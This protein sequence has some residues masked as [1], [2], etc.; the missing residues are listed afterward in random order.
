MKKSI[1]IIFSFVLLVISCKES[2]TGPLPN[3]NSSEFFPNS[4]GNYYNYNVLVTDSSGMAQTGT[5]KSYYSGDTTLLLTPYQIKVDT[6]QISNVQSINQSDFRI[7][8][9]G[10]FNFVGIDTTG[11]SGLVPDSLR[12]G[13]SFDSEYRLIYQPLE[14]DQTWPVYKAIANYMIYKFDFFTVDAKIILKDTL[15]LNFQI[16]P[17]TKSVYKIRYQAKLVTDITLPPTVYECFAWAAENIGFI[18]WEGDS[19]LINFFVGTN[20]YPANTTVIE[21]LYSYK[22]L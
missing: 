20:I 18:R 17:E 11:F 21:E 13:I 3:V 2:A 9:T 14:L 4:D 22:T 12:N 1:A 5:R 15:V 6:F 19:E 16:T 10:V 7:G 8:S